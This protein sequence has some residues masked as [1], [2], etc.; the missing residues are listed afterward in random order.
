ML[1]LIDPE[2][3]NQEQ[4]KLQ[5][6]NQNVKQKINL[7]I[8][9]ARRKFSPV[10][11]EFMRQLLEDMRYDWFGKLDVNMQAKED[12]ITYY[13]FSVSD[14]CQQFDKFLST[15]IFAIENNLNH[16]WHKAKLD[17]VEPEYQNNPADIGTYITPELYG[18]G[19][20]RPEDF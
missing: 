7:V 3:T 16:I 17:Q 18:E 9:D 10:K 12:E 11:V 19:Y 2:F 6:T 5:N 15:E 4:T 8:T 13:G 20:C 1:N 14:Y